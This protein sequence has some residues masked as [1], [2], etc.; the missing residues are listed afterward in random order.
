MAHWKGHS[1]R[2][3]KAAEEVQAKRD[4][5]RYELSLSKW[6]KRRRSA[7]YY[8]RKNILYYIS[9]IMFMRGIEPL[10]FDIPIT[11]IIYKHT[12]IVNMVLITVGAALSALNWIFNKGRKK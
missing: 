9:G 3:L 2:H 11:D 4:E 12:F 8:I 1:D 7:V 5:Y 6:F 10:A